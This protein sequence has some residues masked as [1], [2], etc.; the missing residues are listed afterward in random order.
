MSTDGK[1]SHDH[2]GQQY[3]GYIVV[4]SFIGGGNWRNPPTC[5]KSLTNFIT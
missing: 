1:S 4:V 2:F 3:L 5:R